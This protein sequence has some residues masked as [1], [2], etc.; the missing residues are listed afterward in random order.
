[1]RAFS[2]SLSFSVILSAS[3]FMDLLPLESSSSI[4]AHSSSSSS[5]IWDFKLSFS[6]SKFLN[7]LA[8]LESLF[9][10]RLSCLL[11]RGASNLDCLA[12]VC[13]S[14]CGSQ[15]APLRGTLGETS[16]GVVVE[17]SVGVVVEVSVGV[18]VEVS[19]GVVVEVS[20]P[21]LHQ[22]FKPDVHYSGEKLLSQLFSTENNL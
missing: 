14:L 15:V 3:L 1:M 18:V 2:D 17:V 10:L 5:S 8:S 21:G 4:L 12:S 16:V 7:F 11:V 22:R 13:G 19:V 9:L 20:G 6:F